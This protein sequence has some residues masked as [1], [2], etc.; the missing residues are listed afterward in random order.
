MGSGRSRNDAASAELVASMDVVVCV[1][2]SPSITWGCS[3]CQPE[4][5]HRFS[6]HRE[7]N[8][9]FF[10]NV[11]EAVDGRSWALHRG[12]VLAAARICWPHPLAS[13]PRKYARHA[14]ESERIRRRARRSL[15][16]PRNSG[17]RQAT[18]TS[19]TGRPLQRRRRR[20]SPAVVLVAW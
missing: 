17:H 11:S 10:G 18:Q 16:R 1:A 19:C 2:C 3:C 20:F 4:R 5:W 9:N 14:V 8:C 6:F 13:W 15:K 7:C 12:L